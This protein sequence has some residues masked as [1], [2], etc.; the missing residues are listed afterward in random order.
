MTTRPPRPYDTVFPGEYNFVDEPTYKQLRVK[1]KNWDHGEFHGHFYGQDIEAAQ[2]TLNAGKSLLRCV[3]SDTAVIERIAKHFPDQT[4]LVWVDTML[5][6]ANERLAKLNDSLRI[7]R[8]DG[9]LQTEEN[10][11]SVK[12]TADYVFK[13]IGSIK[14]DCLR[15]EQFIASIINK[16]QSRD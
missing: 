4:V 5:Y 16:E 12:P 14:E 6:V 9:L 2:K 13:P 3:L 8:V 15:F 10:R 11:N 1:S 7:E